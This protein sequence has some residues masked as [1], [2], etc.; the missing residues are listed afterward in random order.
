MLL[1]VLLSF[2]G[3]W[4]VRVVGSGKNGKEKKKKKGT[5]RKRDLGAVA[6]GRASEG[7]L[8]GAGMDAV[9]FVLVF[10]LWESESGLT[11]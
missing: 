4:L 9:F 2:L 10:F 8:R 5:P 11:G 7:A 3:E 1:L 6:P